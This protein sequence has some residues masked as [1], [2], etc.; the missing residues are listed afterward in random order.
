MAQLLVHLK[1]FNETKRIRHPLWYGD[2]NF[3]LGWSVIKKQ[4]MVGTK[5]ACHRGDTFLL[6]LLCHGRGFWIWYNST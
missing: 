4:A 2:D 1:D 5:A 3:A 6:Q